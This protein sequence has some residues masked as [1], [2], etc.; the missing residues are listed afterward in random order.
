MFHSSCAPRVEVPE[1]ILDEIAKLFAEL[2]FA[3]CEQTVARWSRVAAS[4][5]GDTDPP[6]CLANVASCEGRRVFTVTR[7]DWKRLRTHEGTVVEMDLERTP[8]GGVAEW[9]SRIACLAAE[10]SVGTE[11]IEVWRY[12]ENDQPTLKSIERYLILDNLLRRLNLPMFAERT[13][14]EDTPKL[15]KHLREHVFI[16]KERPDKGRWEPKTRSVE[17]LMFLSV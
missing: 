9:S 4:A 17:R 7:A 12:K 10:C 2:I 13:G 15:R 5:P 14:T 3:D 8:T 16:V 11:R 1:K 6:R